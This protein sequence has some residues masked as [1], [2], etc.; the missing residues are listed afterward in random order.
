MKVSPTFATKLEVYLFVYVYVDALEERDGE[1]SVSWH[2][3]SFPPPDSHT[4]LYYKF[5]DIF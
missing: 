2:T 4:K 3:E 5:E 1:D